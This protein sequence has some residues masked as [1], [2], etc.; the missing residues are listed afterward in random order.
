MPLIFISQLLFLSP[1]ITVGL[2]LGT[3]SSLAR[4]YIKWRKKSNIGS[5]EDDNQQLIS[6]KLNPAVQLG[7]IRHN[8]RGDLDLNSWWW[9]AERM[10]ERDSN[11]DKNY[12]PEFLSTHHHD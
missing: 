5:D 8:W 9:M 10:A 1:T 4:F 2:H 7:K 12:K 11:H 6:R 3:S